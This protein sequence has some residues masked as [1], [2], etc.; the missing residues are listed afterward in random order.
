MS[1]M[2]ETTKSVNVAKERTGAPPGGLAVPWF[3]VVTLAVVMAYAA[4][5]WLI[6]LRGDVGAIERTQ[7][8]FADWLRESTLSLPVFVFAVLGAL[9][10]ALRWF[11]PAPR[12]RAVLGTAL[13]VAAAGTLAGIVE[14]AAS[15]AYDYRLQSHMLQMMD[16]MRHSCVGDSCL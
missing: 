1:E 12:G 16:S 6:S 14:L 13:V 8:P 5:F 11:G 7:D 2:S 4:G 10:L 15:S 9:T 3:T